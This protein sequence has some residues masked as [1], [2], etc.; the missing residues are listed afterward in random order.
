V[1]IGIT[2]LFL[3][4]T[5]I[6]L[7][8]RMDPASLPDAPR[9][10]WIPL[11]VLALSW[12]FVYPLQLA[13]LRHPESSPRL[14]ARAIFIEVP[15]A[16]LSVPIVMVIL[17]FVFQAA[18]YLFGPSATPTAPLESLARSPNRF[19]PLA[20]VVLAVSVG[21]V[22]EEVFFRG[23]LYNALRQ[24]LRWLVAAVLQ[25]AAFGLFHP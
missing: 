10:L 20:L 22:A 3:A 21:P 9:W 17:T 19:E 6:A 11:S 14:R 13:R 16:L 12:M 1:L 4:R 15:F 2:P 7:I 8:G 23:F 5:A 18:A 24:R 25:A